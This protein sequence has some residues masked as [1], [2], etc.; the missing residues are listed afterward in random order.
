MFMKKKAMVLAI[1]FASGAINASTH[2]GS[3]PSLL[4]SKWAIGALCGVSAGATAYFGYKWN[5]SR[6]KRSLDSS[7]Y[8]NRARSNFL[9]L[10]GELEAGKTISA[11]SWTT[12]NEDYANLVGW[13]DENRQKFEH[14]LSLCEHG[15]GKLGNSKNTLFAFLNEL[16]TTA[17]YDHN[18][19]TK[20]HKNKSV[21]YG[22][23]TGTF[24][25]TAG[26][27]LY[28]LFKNQRAVTL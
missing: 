6:K 27:G 20:V 28:Q 3:L 11:D 22:V 14:L 5:E 23:M 1:L 25:L 2:E 10:K 8:T 18:K 13:S 24:A 15:V 9:R 19:F 21:L 4:P 17:D 16:S 12:H 26:I 7:S